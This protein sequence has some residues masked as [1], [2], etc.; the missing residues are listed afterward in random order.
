MWSPRLAVLR[1]TLLGVYY[2]GNGNQVRFAHVWPWAWFIEIAL[3]YEQVFYWSIWIKIQCSDFFC[4]KKPKIRIK[5]KEQFLSKIYLLFPKPRSKVNP[6]SS[7]EI[8]TFLCLLMTH[9]IHSYTAVNQLLMQK[10]GQKDDHTCLTWS[11]LTKLSS[12]YFLTTCSYL[13]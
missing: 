12:A 11:I 8:L 9:F 2:S 3:I 10:T 1:F 6:H 4:S 13:K 5:M 7:K